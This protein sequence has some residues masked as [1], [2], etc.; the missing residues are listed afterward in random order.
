MG[1]K[2]NLWL[3]IEFAPWFIVDIQDKGGSFYESY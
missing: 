1:E 2:V 3:A